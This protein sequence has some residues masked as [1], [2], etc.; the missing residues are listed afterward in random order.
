MR[1]HHYYALV[2]VGM[3]LASMLTV[4]A[5]S[6]AAPGPVS[7]SSPTAS[8]ATVTL[9]PS[10][11]GAP[12][13]RATFVAVEVPTATRGAPP[14]RPPSPVPTSPTGPWVQLIAPPDQSTVWLGQPIEVRA[15]ISDTVGIARMELWVNETQVI[16]EFTSLLT[17]E[18]THSFPW[19]PSATGRSTLKVRVY[20]TKNEYNESAPVL[21]HVESHSPA[22]TRAAEQLGVPTVTPTPVATVRP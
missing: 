6:Q 17:T 13:A 5:C 20:N 4:A 16:T 1:E 18:L 3:L 22:M 9:T 15:A 10:G 7:V 2:T 8:L 12:V 21:L 19:S 14:S 11:K